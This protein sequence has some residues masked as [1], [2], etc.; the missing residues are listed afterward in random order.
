MKLLKKILGVTLLEVMLVL[1]IAAMIIVMS[2]RYYQSATSS[3]QANAALSQVQAIIAAADGLAQSGGSYAG[4]VSS[5][6]LAPLLPARGLYMPWGEAVTIAAPS[7]STFTIAFT[8]IP[9]GVCPLLNARLISNNHI[10]ATGTCNESAVSAITY[11]YNAA[12]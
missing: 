12:V 2:V 11:T 1:A 9:R 3:S 8:S 5:T 7:A 10:S 4:T 6:A